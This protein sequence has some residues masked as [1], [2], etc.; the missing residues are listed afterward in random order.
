MK[1]ISKY[2][3]DKLLFGM[4]QPDVIAV[5]GNP[6]KKYKDEDENEI[7]LYNTLKFRLTFYE[8]AN[9]KLGYIICGS[10]KLTI[11]DQPIIGLKISEA[12]KNLAEKGITKWSNDPFD[13]YENY[14][15][16]DNWITLQSEFGEIV[17]V[18]LGAMINDKDEFDWKF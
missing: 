8:E 7:F 15:N 16:E 1:I 9:F 10:E 6:D 13:T 18:E 12:K 17:K 11:F 5:Y 3:I 14:L 4:K 2:G